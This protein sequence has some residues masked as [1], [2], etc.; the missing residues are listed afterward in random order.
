MQIRRVPSE[1]LLGRGWRE[2]LWCWSSSRS[3]WGQVPNALMSC[4]LQQTCN[5][6][7]G[8]A[9]AA[10]GSSQALDH[11]GWREPSP[12]C[13]RKLWALQLGRGAP[14][15]SC[16]FGRTPRGV[17]RGD[18]AAPATQGLLGEGLAEGPSRDARPAV[19]AAGDLPQ[20]SGL[21][22]L[23]PQSGFIYSLF[24]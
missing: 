22:W 24:E 7:L 23:H 16:S 15:P 10:G 19:P 17:S 14:G 21:T 9:S 13:R 1:L 11:P 12:A 20:S 5:C 2:R 18:G 4:R 3:V 6:R 8:K